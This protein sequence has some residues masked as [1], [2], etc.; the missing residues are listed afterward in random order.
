MPNATFVLEADWSR[1]GDYLD[2]GEDLTSYVQDVEYRRGR[3]YASQLTGRSTAGELIATLK[4]TD[5]RFSSFNTASP[6]TG[7]L[8]PGVK[9]RLR[10]TAPSAKNLWTGFL[11][12][13]EP[14]P[15][16]DGAH[17][18]RLYAIG[19]LGKVNGD[20]TVRVEMKTAILT[21]DAIA[22]VLTQAGWPVADRD[23]DTG[24]TTM[25]R[26]FSDEAEALTVLREIEET[27]SGFIWEMVDGKIA[28]F[29]RH[30]RLISPYTVSQAVWTDTAGGAIG[31]YPIRQ[32]DPLREIFNVF[33]ARV[34]LYTVGSIVTLWTLAENG[35]AS[36]LFTPGQVLDF[37]ANY[38][39]PD[40]ATDAFGVNAWTTPV[41]TTD[42]TANTAADGSG[43]NVS[44]DF[45]VASSKFAKSMKVTLTNTGAVNA[46]LT[47]LQARGT[48]LTVSDPIRIIT[49]DAASIT[50][51]G[52]R[53]Y[54]LGTRFIPNTDDARNRNAWVSSIYSVPIPV[55]SVTLFGNRSAAML[56]EILTRDVNDRVTI[57]ASAARSSL[58]INEDFFVE[59]VQGRIDSNLHH[60]VTYECS[61]ASA[62]GGFWVLDTG[63]L[64]TSTRLS[65]V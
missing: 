62:F 24:Q 64:G 53:V 33:E 21:G 35:A 63:V 40:S 52:R 19:P 65:Y 61:P 31:Y 44:A 58:G 13:I 28:F 14:Q 6:L 26:W 42:F 34:L 37:W 12:R 59:A 56:T 10:T 60:V 48:P 32:E 20:E 51:Y 7:L 5:Q 1:D 57:V 49:E 18:V 54:P 47:M 22:H 16:I 46:Y 23:L 8:L 4:N 2:T 39:N 50:K 17:T 38:P 36:P 15:S 41:V 9:I 25:D 55:L 27:E 45:T 30:A 29:D 43:S 11:D 3:D